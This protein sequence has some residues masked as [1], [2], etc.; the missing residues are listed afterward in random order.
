ML[1][2]ASAIWLHIWYEV[3]GAQAK[4]LDFIKPCHLVNYFDLVY[5]FKLH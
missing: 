2:V 3:C 4:L 5:M 1:L